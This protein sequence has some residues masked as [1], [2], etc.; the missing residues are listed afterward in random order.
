M[1]DQVIEES[2]EDD[3][4]CEIDGRESFENDNGKIP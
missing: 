3:E 2:D 4:W 1:P